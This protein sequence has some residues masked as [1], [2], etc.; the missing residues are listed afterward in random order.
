[1]KLVLDWECVNAS[2]SN[3]TPA[4]LGGRNRRC[5]SWTLSRDVA[6]GG[7][8]GRGDRPTL[9][10]FRRPPDGTRAPRCPKSRRRRTKFTE[11]KKKITSEQSMH[12]DQSDS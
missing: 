5:G 7:E 9:V 6:R 4:W 2:S 12:S 11:I 8:G 10:V 1:M 3:S